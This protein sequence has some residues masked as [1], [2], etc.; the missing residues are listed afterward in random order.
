MSHHSTHPFTTTNEALGTFVVEP[1]T[2]LKVSTGAG[3][4]AIFDEAEQSGCSGATNTTEKN[5]SL[6]FFMPLLK[7]CRSGN[8]DGDDH[9]KLMG[10]DDSDEPLLERYVTCFG[11]D[12]YYQGTS[13]PFP[14]IGETLMGMHESFLEVATKLTWNQ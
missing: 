1:P 3:K 2:L 13:Q 12:S 10:E 11:A 4:F 8:D 7:F 6:T 14:S 5:E 9:N